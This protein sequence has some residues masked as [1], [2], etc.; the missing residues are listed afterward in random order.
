MPINKI[1]ILSSGADASGINAS[2]R[3][4]CLSCEYEG[5]E[6]IGDKYGFNSLLKQEW[7]SLISADMYNL[8]QRGGAILDSARCENF[9]TDE[10]ALLAA[11][12]SDE[13]EVDPLIM[14][15]GN[16]SFKGAQHLQ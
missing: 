1:V 7:R 3:A 9:K 12:K 14:L 2:L 15:G 11:K 13:N 6:T 8:I 16:G 10:G 5:I 4:I